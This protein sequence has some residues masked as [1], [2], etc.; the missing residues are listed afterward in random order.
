M[1][2]L[3]NNTPQKEI[4]SWVEKYNKFNPYK[5]TTKEHFTKHDMIEFGKFVSDKTEI[6]DLLDNWIKWKK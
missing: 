3:R 6:E 4:P 5:R 1:S 2:I